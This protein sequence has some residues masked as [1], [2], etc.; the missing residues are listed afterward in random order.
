M[1]S[2][3]IRIN[4][5]TETRRWTRSVSD[6]VGISGTLPTHTSTA[7]HAHWITRRRRIATSTVSGPMDQEPQKRDRHDRSYS[8]FLSQSTM[9]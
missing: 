9:C 3:P 2:T 6:T 1:T 7:S 5:A 4:V 8:V